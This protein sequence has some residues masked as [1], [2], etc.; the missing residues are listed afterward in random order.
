M[1]G[2]I[3]NFV[4]VSAA[5]GILFLFAT[6]WNLRSRDVLYTHLEE[7]EKVTPTQN[8][9]VP[10]DVLADNAEI[11]EPTA[12]ATR[13][14]FLEIATKWGTDKVTVH[15]YNYMYEKYLEPIRDKSLKMLEIGLGCDMSY[16]PGKSYYTWQEFLPNVDLYYIEYDKECVR[17]WAQNMTNVKIYTGSQSDVDFLDKFINSSGGGFDII[18]DDGGHT[19]EQQIT[20]LDKL[21]PVV[22]PGGMYFCE[23][24]QTSYFESYG[25]TPGAKTMMGVIQELL[26]DLNV[27]VQGAPPLQHEVGREM[28]SVECGEEIC[29]FFKKDLGNTEVRT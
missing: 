24:L 11:T 18:I 9:T 7:F 23:D 8:T 2:R 20:S 6:L 3:F 13:P 17:K 14:S 12:G 16:G 25:A 10:E 29:A 26:N 1:Q 4:S 27:N 21:F 22:K 28:R 5:V 15:H 19:M